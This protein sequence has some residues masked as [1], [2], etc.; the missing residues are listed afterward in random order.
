MT[1]SISTGSSLKS[2]YNFASKAA[3][4][5]YYWAKKTLTGKTVTI[6]NDSLEDVRLRLDKLARLCEAFKQDLD[7]F[8]AILAAF[9][10]KEA[11]AL[12]LA[13][14]AGSLPSSD[15]SPELL[16]AIEG[17]S[18]SYIAAAANVRDASE[19]ANQLAELIKEKL[20]SIARVRKKLEIRETMY[21]QMTEDEKRWHKA[22]ET[23]D[24]KVMERR[25]KAELATDRYDQITQECRDMA[26][27]TISDKDIFQ[28]T[29]FN[30]LMQ[31]QARVFQMLKD[32][33][34]N[35]GSTESLSTVLSSKSPGN[36][37]TRPD[38]QTS[39]NSRVSESPSDH[40]HS[41]SSVAR[42]VRSRSTTEQ[43]QLDFS[44][45][46]FS[47]YADPGRL[48]FHEAS[49]EFDLDSL[50]LQEPSL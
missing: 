7:S 17:Y 10:A 21:L 29:V 22:R 40:R 26:E 46:Q 13:T 14:V 16:S 8:L 4:E 41:Q 3:S 45:P 30:K 28:A 39:T 43:Q 19:A 25:Q 32:T 33:V 18:T 38:G 2:W 15:C 37:V 24:P 47:H 31:Q 6:P 9:N 49:N 23:G 11:T 12:T 34:V 20:A 50:D 36:A 5:Q 44:I 42:S 1:T 27:T 48:H 35:H